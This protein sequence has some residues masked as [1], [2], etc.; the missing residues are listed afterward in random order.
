VYQYTSWNTTDTTSK[1][2]CSFG[3]IS[4]QGNGY[5]FIR[6]VCKASGSSPGTSFICGK[7]TKYPWT[8]YNSNPLAI[9]NRVPGSWTIQLPEYCANAWGN[10]LF[11]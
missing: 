8:I 7:T 6:A 3:N 10:N 2:R 5:S 9:E 11:T 4:D 1:G